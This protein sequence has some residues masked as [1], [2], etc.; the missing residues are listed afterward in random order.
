MLVVFGA[1]GTLARYGLQGLVQEHTGMGFPTGTL[2]VNLAG[3][4]L[5][6]AVAQLGLS[7]AALPPDWRIALTVGFLGAFTTFSTFGYETLRMLEEA[8]WLRATEYV[9]A[10]LLGGLLLMSAGAWLADKL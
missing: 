10:S 5:F 7:R 3:C 2:S 8:E 6:G 9:G 4:F 1:A